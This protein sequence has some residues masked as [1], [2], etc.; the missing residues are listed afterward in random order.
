MNI[1]D[2]IKDIMKGMEGIG[3]LLTDEM[4]LAEF[5]FRLSAL[6]QVENNVVLDDVIKCLCNHSI[7][8]RFPRELINKKCDDCDGVL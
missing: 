3:G 7:E 5:E 2:K 6:K 4:Y 8:E 1:E